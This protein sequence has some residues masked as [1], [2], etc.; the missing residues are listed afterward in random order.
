MTWH[1]LSACIDTV[2]A[3]MAA[4]YGTRCAVAATALV[5]DLLNGREAEA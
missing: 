5:I 4:S 3:A 2:E 1:A